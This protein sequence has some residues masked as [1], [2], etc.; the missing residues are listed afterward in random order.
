MGSGRHSVH[1][2]SSVNGSR[3]T[4]LSLQVT[5]WIL[6]TQSSQLDMADNAFDDQY[7]GCT[8]EMEKKAPQLLKEEM[9]MNGLLRSEWEKAEEY[10]K[11]N[12][13]KRINY[14]KQFNDF[15]GTALVAY[16]GDIA[17][18]FNRAVREFRQNSLNFHFKAFHYYLTRALQLLSTTE[19]YT[20]YRGSKTKFYHSK[21]GSVRF[22]QFT[23]SSLD[24]TVA[25]R[26]YLGAGGT[27]FT[28]RTCS[29][30]D[31]QAFSTKPH[32]KEVLIPGYE[33]YQKVTVQG[34]NEKRNEIL[35]ES[36]KKMKSTFN[37]FHISTSNTRV[38]DNN[39]ARSGESG[40]VF[41]VGVVWP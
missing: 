14:P 39:F 10:W 12:M 8:K 9:R 19:C 2:V 5:S 36:P 7:E 32:E 3:D 17:V 24:R 33:V 31:I 37:C 18:E 15:H 41:Q 26:D 29:G 34:T 30:V 28:I 1:A 40:T 35:L 20:V 22:G 38:G 25:T 16:T 13:K 6:S 23:S 27:L 11:Q 4:T 21:R